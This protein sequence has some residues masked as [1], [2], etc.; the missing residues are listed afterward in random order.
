M[1]EQENHAPG[2]SV[3]PAEPGPGHAPHPAPS[4]GIP[5][6]GKAGKP[7]LA[8]E[9]RRRRIVPASTAYV[10]AVFAALQG[11]DVLR[12]A[13]EL[14]HAVLVVATWIGVLGFPLNLFFAWQAHDSD[15][16][17]WT[18]LGRRLPKP[19]WILV[20][21]L[22][23]AAGGVAAWRVWGQ[24][25]PP[26]RT[27]TVLV[28]DLQNWTGE[29][30]FDGTLEPALGL[31][32]EGASFINAFRRE[33][34]RK[35]ANDLKLEGANLDEKR[36]RLVAQRE[37]IGVVTSGSI[38]KTASGYRVSLR[39]VDAFT[40]KELVSAKEDVAT[41]DAALSAAGKLAARVR[42]ALGD[43]TPEAT[44]LKDAETFSAGSL[45]A[46]HEYALGMASTEEGK[47]D[48]AIRHFLAAVK[49]DPQMGRAWSGLAVVEQNRGRNVEAERYFEKAL[50][51]VDRMSEREKY[52]SRSVY[53]LHKDD[54]DKAI[55][56]LVPLLQ[57]YPGDNAGHANLAVA[58]QLKR[59]FKKA[60]ESGR[61][62]V[63][64]SPKKVAQRNNLGLF[65]MYAGD[66]D[67]AIR[68]QQKVLELSPGFPGG[69]VGLALAQY[70]SGRRDE[71]IATWNRLGAFGGDSASIAAEGLAD[72]AVLEG[73]LGDARA[74]L[75]KGIEDDTQA[76]REE[77]LGRKLAMLGSI[78]LATGQ[79]AKALAAAERGRKVTS[80]DYVLFQV[81]LVFLGA[82]DD[83]KARAIA[84]DLEKRLGIDAR[85][86]ALVLNGAIATR[87][88][89]H[90]EAVAKMKAATLLVD[91]WPARYGLGRAY[92]E[93]GAYP[94]AQQELEAAVM[95]RGEATDVFLQIVP[96]YRFFGQAQYHLGRAQEALKSPMA[97]ETF[98]AFLSAKRGSEDPLVADAKK[99]AGVP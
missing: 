34:A 50:A 89:N 98:K 60:L 78:H 4:S 83:R 81:G 79:P 75:E 91:A 27:L 7:S 2:P 48:E 42:T 20:G 71:A 97:V 73:R 62:A 70:A 51:H 64:I 68:E 15:D 69:Y 92:L 23:I 45:D 72:A 26:P 14:P 82:G 63:E 93:A 33:N 31:A 3:N 32:L 21:V 84:E 25:R 85:M 36:A 5:E 28:A 80:A 55:E 30:V 54:V 41:K 95:R 18:S 44:Q 11:V 6:P 57:K 43:A 61:R 49:I 46:A 87:K 12:N 74:L 24:A 76:S 38:E 19:T 8:A 39:A 66:F 10:V 77:A 22:A 56:D 13:F 96:T 1:V 47:T 58:W 99:R 17:I 86:Y 59:D 16:D 9:I 37:G 88:K 90:V 53:Y 29:G 65:A 40:G 67:T 94:Q 52:R 35:V